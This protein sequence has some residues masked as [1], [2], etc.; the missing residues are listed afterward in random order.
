VIPENIERSTVYLRLAFGQA[1]RPDP[2]VD[3]AI[4]GS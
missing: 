1:A 4:R 3:N 2:W